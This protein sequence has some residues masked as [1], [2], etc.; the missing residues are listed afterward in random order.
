MSVFDG[1]DLNSEAAQILQYLVDNGLTSLADLAHELALDES[2]LEE[3]LEALAEDNLVR[4]DGDEESWDVTARGVDVLS[5]QSLEED[6]PLLQ[7][8]DELD[9]SNGHQPLERELGSAGFAID[10]D[11]E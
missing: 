9:S 6:L 10:H 1:T 8:L 11:E 2:E 5:S 4:A 3:T 7:D